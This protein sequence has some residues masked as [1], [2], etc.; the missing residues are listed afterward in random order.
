M[1]TQ[2][3]LEGPD[4]EALLARVRA[5]HGSAAR[6]VRAE[7]VRTGGVGGFFAKQHYEINVEVEDVQV[8]AP[9]PR[10]ASI[11]DLAD[12]V[13]DSERAAT[14]V[15]TESTGFAAVLA[16]LGAAAGDPPPAVATAGT[17]VPAQRSAP[18]AESR[19]RARR[20]ATTPAAPKS[21]VP[22]SAALKPVRT[23]AVSATPGTD[24]AVRTVRATPRAGAPGGTSVG[25][26]AV[27]ARGTVAR[28]PAPARA[29]TTPAPRPARRRPPRTTGALHAAAGAP[30]SGDL[31]EQ[32]VDLGLPE[33]LLP[34]A[35]PGPLVPALTDSLRALPAAPRTPVRSGGI[36]A[37]VGPSAVA[38]DA[39]RSIARDLD[40]PRSAVVVVDP[41]RD[42]DAER[43]ATAWRRRGRTTVVVV[44]APLSAGAAAHAR[45]YLRALAPDA[46]WAA[47]EATRKPR[48]VGAWTRAV[49][50]VDALALTGVDETSDPAAVLE[51][52]IP[53]GR[54]EGRRATAAAWAALLADRV[55]A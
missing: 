55:A 35:V 45:A 7:K 50:G 8:P 42:D 13:S 4:L 23:R 20:P 30:L 52:G 26:V 47:V 15:S 24:V 43:K 32:L 49:G 2:L 41:A 40:L 5:E 54:L 46:T 37:V 27:R 44:E 28:R 22:T 48:D 17:R 29:V 31:T 25:T 18:A 51:L 21:A 16:R 11:L 6:I 36:L 39:A 9:A 14:T 38:Q 12:E 53:V 34:S 19:P 3:Q 1:P 10:P 33:H